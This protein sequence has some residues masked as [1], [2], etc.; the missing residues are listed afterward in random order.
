MCAP[1]HPPERKRKSGRLQAGSEA[2]VQTSFLPG[3]VRFAHSGRGLEGIPVPA[4]STSL[5]S[6]PLHQ[7][8]LLL[9]RGLLARE[10]WSQ[11][12][13]GDIQTGV[14]SVTSL[15]RCGQGASAPPAAA[16]T[17]VMLCLGSFCPLLVSVGAGSARHAAATQAPR[18]GLEAPCA[19]SPPTVLLLHRAL[20]SLERTE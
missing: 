1:Q 2:S 18:S 11:S 10:P 13:S 6:C 4:P 5:P 8:F 3:S 19:T 17:L 7:R 16:V 20:F 14:Q 12:D 9:A 15:P